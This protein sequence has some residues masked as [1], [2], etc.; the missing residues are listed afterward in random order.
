MAV[1]CPEKELQRLLIEYAGTITS[2]PRFLA[3]L[4]LP[5]STSYRYPLPAPGSRTFTG[6]HPRPDC[7]EPDMKVEHISN[8]LVLTL[9][10]HLD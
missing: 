4:V 8:F 9:L 2:Q 10:Y 7:I 6:T 1:Q 3:H 5:P